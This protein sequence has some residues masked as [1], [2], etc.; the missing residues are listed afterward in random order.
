MN[1]DHTIDLLR[2]LRPSDAER[3]DEIFPVKARAD[4]LAMIT[5]QAHTVAH[6]SDAHPA[7]RRR[8]PLTLGVI[9]MTSVAVPTVAAVVLATGSAVGPTP[10]DAVSFHTTRHGYILASVT[11]PFA[12][13][14]RLNAAFAR[15]GLHITINLIPVSPSAVGRVVY[16]GISNSRG[17]QIQSLR[18]GD[19][20]VSAATGCLIGLKIPK[21]FTATA[22]IG[23][24]RQAKPGETY[25]SGAS[26]FAPGEPLHCSGLLGAT[27][28]RALPVLARDKL[29]VR[30]MEDVE[31]RTRHTGVSSRARILT[32]P[33]THNYIWTANLSAQGHVTIQ[34]EP[35]PWPGTPGAGSHFNDGC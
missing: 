13:R 18:Q 9:G 35:R 20:C 7:P 21:H 30:W 27:V 4:L 22:T 29:T 2:A 16:M 28:A 5:D 26:A 19:G 11:D 6:N 8:R 1:A 14:T 24:G 12:T 3:V 31:I 34:T 23:L 10:A 33:P 32:Q 25:A 17:P 15:Q